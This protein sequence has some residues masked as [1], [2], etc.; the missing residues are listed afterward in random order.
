MT[1]KSMA[2][3]LC[4]SVLL[5]APTDAQ[6]RLM[7]RYSFEID[8]SDS[9]GDADGTLENGAMI[10]DGQVILSGEGSS[11]V[12]PEFLG[13]H[14]ALP[15]GKIALNTYTDASIE[16]WYTDRGTMTWGK[17]FDFGDRIDGAGTHYIYYT[18]RSG[19]WTPESGP[20]RTTRVALSGTSPGFLREYVIDGPVQPPGET[21]LVV[22][23]NASARPPS[24]DMYLNGKP[25]G[26]IL[27]RRSLDIIGPGFAYLGRSLYSD[28][29]LKGS[30]NEFRVWSNALNPN[31]VAASFAAGPDA[32]ITEEEQPGLRRAAAAGIVSILAAL[33]IVILL[34]RFRK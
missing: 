28:P 20:A 3:L 32:V 30:I 11:Q 10:V 14:V 4:A 23:V 27:L 34:G 33:G 29:M 19:Y 2:T 16:A 18:P 5:L 24:L 9:V 17:L 15:S 6:A 13:P 7:H 12:L 8:A 31:E 1:G 21:H 25:A 26:S 22:V